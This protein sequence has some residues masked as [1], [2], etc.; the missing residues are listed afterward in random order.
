VVVSALAMV[1]C[2]QAGRTAA[3]GAVGGGIIGAGVGALA[4]R[5]PTGALIGAGIGAT[6]GAIAASNNS[7]P[8]PGWCTWQDRNTGQLYYAP[9]PR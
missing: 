3:G 8:P 2:T 6:A 5:T 9:C 1:G 4:T 7:Q